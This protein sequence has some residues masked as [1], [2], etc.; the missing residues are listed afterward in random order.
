MTSLLKKQ[1][2]VD[3]TS[4]LELALTAWLRNVIDALRL[5][6]KRCNYL[7]DNLSAHKVCLKR[8]VITDLLIF[9]LTKAYYIEIRNVKHI[10]V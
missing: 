9:V 10:Q 6:V 8:G 2:R 4:Y 5:F 1:K 7:P 3:L